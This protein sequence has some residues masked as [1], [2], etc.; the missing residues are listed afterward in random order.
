M[1]IDYIEHPPP[2]TKGIPIC[3]VSIP[4]QENPTDCHLFYH[5]VFGDDNA[6]KLI[7]KSCGRDMMYNPKTMSCDWP[8]NVVLLKSSCQLKK[9]E[10][11]RNETVPECPPGMVMEKCAIPCENPGQVVEEKGCKQCQCIDNYYS[12][13]KVQCSDEVMEEMDVDEYE[14]TEE[15]TEEDGLNRTDI[16]RFEYNKQS[17]VRTYTIP[18]ILIIPS[19]VT[20]PEACTEN[21]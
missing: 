19:T 1:Y 7:E 16:G 9:E 20:P 12:C 6:P 4:H 15:P 2:T 8:A 17:I 5:C 14:Q 21:R 13:H 3:D 18:P 10:E 11:S